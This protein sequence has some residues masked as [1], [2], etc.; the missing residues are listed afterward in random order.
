MKTLAVVVG[1]AL[2]ALLLVP[3]AMIVVASFSPVVQP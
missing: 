1:A 3:L 2:I